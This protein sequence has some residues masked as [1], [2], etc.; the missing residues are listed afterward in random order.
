MKT[1]KITVSPISLKTK[2]EAKQVGNIN[3][4]LTKQIEVNLD[5][6]TAII[7]QPIA[8]TW[9]PA[10]FNG[11]RNNKNWLEQQVFGLDFDSGATPEEIIELL[12]RYGIIPNV[13][14]TTMSDSETLRK[15]RVVFILDVVIQ[16]FKTA[17]FIIKALMNLV[18]GKS[19]KATKDPSRMFYPSGATKPIFVHDE[20]IKTEM[21]MDTLMTVAV[22]EAVSKKRSIDEVVKNAEI[23]LSSYIYREIVVCPQND[24]REND[25]RENEDENDDEIYNNGQLVKDFDWNKAKDEVKIFNDFIEGKWLTHPQLF[26]I[27]TS[28]RWIEGG[29]KLM[30]ETMNKWNKEGKTAYNQNNFG[31]LPYVSKMKYTPN[32]LANYSL[33]EEDMAKTNIISAVRNLK[34]LVQLGKAEKEI[35]VDEA[36]ERLTDEFGKILTNKEKNKVFIIKVPTGLGKT[37]L[38]SQ[39]QNVSATIAFPTH[40]L[41]NEVA[42]RFNDNGT[43]VLVTPEL[44]KFSESVRT[45][46]ERLHDAGLYSDVSSM[47][48]DIAKNP[49]ESIKLGNSFF[50]N[51]SSQAKSLYSEEDVEMAKEYISLN[52][53]CYNTSEDIVLTTHSKA[54]FVDFAADVMIFDE[55]PLQQ[56]LS[57]KNLAASEL[58]QIINGIPDSEDKLKVAMSK[59]YTRIVDFSIETEFRTTEVIGILAEKRD[60]IRDVILNPNNGIKTTS[61]LS[62]ID[63]CFYIKEDDNQ[64]N[65]VV[66]RPFQGVEN[67][68]VI[69]MSATAAESAYTKLGLNV[70]VIDLGKVKITGKIVQNTKYSYSKTSL[71]SVDKVDNSK[72]RIEVIADKV[73]MLPVITFSDLKNKFNNP[74]KEMHFGNCSGYDGLKGRDIAVVGTYHR[75]AFVYALMALALGEKI[76]NDDLKPQVK[77]VTYNNAKFQLNS[78]KNELMTAIQLDLINQELVQCVGRARVLR[79]DCTVNVYSGFPLRDATKFVR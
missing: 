1:F 26:G 32:N 49:K 46:I 58:K 16:N 60:V 15:F 14:Y 23:P 64:I 74:V 41:K 22:G 68:T 48:R 62:F 69:I 38:L 8:Y 11:I 36:F 24:D 10:L 37:Q 20:F 61:F 19:D 52:A 57:I 70:E 71:L 17:E 73:E 12:S 79:E 67:K 31:I 42:M 40:K 5:E 27:A 39:L 3:N 77:E 76:S 35:S 2:P 29:M 66:R 56:I 28:L 55:C 25:D 21:F 53:K 78:F 59:F 72:Q 18:E 63:S 75:P 13:I 51:A 4:N 54:T 34:G 65:Y 7:S 44:P 43:T 50:K 33:Y 6:F 47:I 45:K 9:T 30:K